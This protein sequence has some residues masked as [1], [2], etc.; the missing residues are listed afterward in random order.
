MKD[1][2]RLVESEVFG[3]FRI[4]V[5]YDEHAECPIREWD[6][7][8]MAMCLDFGRYGSMKTKD[9]EKLNPNEFLER[10]GAVTEDGDLVEPKDWLVL[11]V[12]AYIHSGIT[13]SL[14][15]FSCSWD[16]GCC[17][18]VAI[19]RTSEDFKDRTEEGLTEALKSMV[20]TADKFLTGQ[21]YMY[22]V[23]REVDGEHVDSCHGFFEDPEYVLNEGKDS[24]KY[25]LRSRDEVVAHHAVD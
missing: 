1:D 22:R 8:G 3:P 16:S 7:P 15:K 21:V 17:G 13:I 4:E 6:W 20:E 9:E 25:Y 5:L 24:A 19:D 12:Y 23:V 10:I 18:Y 14:G 2:W 11:P